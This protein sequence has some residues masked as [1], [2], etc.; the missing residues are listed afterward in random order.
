M[1]QP[2]PVPQ[3][4]TETA[5]VQTT[6]IWAR[7]LNV[8]AVPGE[9]FTE[10]KATP[11]TA[12]NWLVPAMIMAIVGAISAIIIFSQ[13]AIVQQVREQQAAM[14]DKQ[15]KAGKITQ[16][17]ADK[18][19][20]MSEKFT[21]PTMLRL[22]GSVGAVATSFGRIFWWGFVLWLLARWLLKREILFK[23]ALEVAGLALMISVLGTIVGLLLSVNLNRA[24]ATPSLALVLKDF[25]MTRKSHLFLGAANVFYFWQ[26][27]ITSLGFAKLAGVPF[28]RAAW[29]VVTFWVLQESLS[30]M[31][32]IGQFA[33]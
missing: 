32:G 21:G 8:F 33:L 6:S 13:P 28:L 15:V 3:A 9:V 27:A 18:M 29:V 30:I 7:L 23:K 22:F 4:L 19:I 11:V 16:A 5:L 25:D 10:V 14:F 1:D 31:L 26:V 12:A 2:P 17:D 24:M 20:E